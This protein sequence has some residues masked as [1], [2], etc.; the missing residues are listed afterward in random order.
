MVPYAYSGQLLNA[1]V[2]LNDQ[3][4]AHG[5]PLK[6]LRRVY[7]ALA[8]VGAPH[9]PSLTLPR[10]GT[11]MWVPG[12]KSKPFLDRATP[13]FLRPL[14]EQQEAIRIEC[15]AVIRNLD[16]DLH[17]NQHLVRLGQWKHFPLYSYGLKHKRNC[18][19]MPQT[20]HILE[21]IQQVHGA[22][23]VFLSLL[24][25][26]T[27]VVPHCGPFNH[28][29]RCHL[30]LHIPPGTCGMRVAAE[31]RTW[32][33][34]RCLIFDDSQE[35]ELWNLSPE[36]Q[37]LLVVDYWHPDLTPEERWGLQTV[38]PFVLQQGTTNATSRGP[39]LRTKL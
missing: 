33:P 14:E 6:K 9:C 20:T 29:L 28:R 34:G 32:L 1:T 24:S 26:C 21:Q 27:H 13:S 10:P 39:E 36:P 12:L 4:L 19:Q 23:Q 5:I 25:G 3:A 8:S 37:A 30:G 18:N 17:P 38:L 7:Q 11:S 15:H 35:H 2:A 31:S 22:G 16:L